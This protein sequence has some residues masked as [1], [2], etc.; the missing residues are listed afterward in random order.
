MIYM[1]R[2]LADRFDSVYIGICATPKRT[3]ACT[4]DINILEF[5]YKSGR[6]QYMSKRSYVSSSYQ[7]TKLALKYVVFQLNNR[8]LI[9]WK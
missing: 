4:I 2:M 5:I 8:F 3:Q 6:E 7:Y 9:Y 1:M